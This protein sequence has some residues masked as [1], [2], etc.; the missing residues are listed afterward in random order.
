MVKLGFFCLRLK[1]KNHNI[2]GDNLRRILRLYEDLKERHFTTMAGAIAFFVIINCGSLFFLIASIFHLFN[3]KIPTSGVF[4]NDYFTHILNFFDENTKR[5][6]ASHIILSVTSL[7]S[8]STLFYH[9]MLIGE[10]IYN[11][12]RKRYY[13][14]HRIVAILLVIIFMLL[15][16]LMIFMII[17][18]NMILDYLKNIWLKS[19]FETLMMMIIPSFIIV[20]FL[21]FV[22]P[23]KLSFKNI[24]PGYL[25]T[26]SSWIISTLAF[27]LYLR[28]FSNFKAFYGIFTMIIIGVIYLYIL[29]IGLI[30][31]LVANEHIPKNRMMKDK[32]QEIL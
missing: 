6:N 21:I 12:K 30:I 26:I 4:A 19:L 22:P 13:L 2:N 1:N 8:S 3:F 25:I 14:M 18:G 27:E 28:F 29:I 17:L 31:G 5:I 24:M 16:L 20:F 11:E 10:I 7:W 15:I 23:Y 9:I 32:I